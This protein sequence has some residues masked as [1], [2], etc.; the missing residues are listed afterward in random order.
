MTEKFSFEAYTQE[1]S[2]HNDQEIYTKLLK[3]IAHSS[4]NLG[5]ILN[6]C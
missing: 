4:K 1:K 3:I 5:K 6:V 2:F